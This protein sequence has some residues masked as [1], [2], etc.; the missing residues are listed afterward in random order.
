TRDRRL[1]RLRQSV[2]GFRV[3]EQ[4][5]TCVVPRREGNMESG[6]AF[7]VERFGHESGQLVFLTRQL[8][9]GAFEA[10]STVGCIERLGVPQIDLELS[11]RELVVCS[12]DLGPVCRRGGK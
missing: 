5:L 1:G 3:V 8:L 4:R 12:Y 9:D 7:L 6:S 10:E 11:A 2:I